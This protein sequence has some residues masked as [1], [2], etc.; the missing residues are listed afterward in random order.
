MQS[1]SIMK[2]I[3]V[4]IVEDNDGLR[5]GLEILIKS[6]PGLE[7]KKVYSNAESAMRRIPDNPPDII[8]M[9][10]NLP[11]ASGIKCT[12][13]IRRTC[14]NVQVLIQTVYEDSELVFQALKAGANGYLLKRATHAQ[15]IEAIHETIAGGAPMSSSIARKVVQSF[16]K[17]PDNTNP[18]SQLTPR[19]DEILSMLAKGFRNKEIAEKLFI[20]PETVRRHVHSIYSK[21]HVRSR[22]EAVVKFLENKSF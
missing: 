9:D 5:E 21:L 11:E 17:T 2:T 7:L 14:P 13:F 19:E 6:T 3:S 4:S 20:S 10:I 15:L 18:A 1:N 16:H 22:T 8:L 12:E